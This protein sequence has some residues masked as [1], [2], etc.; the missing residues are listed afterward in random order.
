MV[1]SIPPFSVVSLSEQQDIEAKPRLMF[2]FSHDM[3]IYSYEEF[4]LWVSFTVLDNFEHFLA[5]YFWPV[6]LKYRY[7]RQEETIMKLTVASDHAG[8]FL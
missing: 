1:C 8:A 3:N 6:L 7:R 5:C 4:N 2:W